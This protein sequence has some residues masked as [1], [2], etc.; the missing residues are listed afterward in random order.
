[1]VRLC[2]WAEITHQ[3]L[4]FDPFASLQPPRRVIW[5]D[6]AGSLGGGWAGGDEQVFRV[7]ASALPP[8]A[9]TEVWAKLFVFAV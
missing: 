4:V 8:S 3:E 6:L 5:P 9:E 1:M 7:P 2:R